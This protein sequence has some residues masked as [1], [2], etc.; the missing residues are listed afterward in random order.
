MEAQTRQFAAHFSVA[1]TSGENTAERDSN[2][3]LLY[4]ARVEAP[5]SGKEPDAGLL[6]YTLALLKIANH[7]CQQP[8]IQAAAALR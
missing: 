7:H 3:E 5:A 6:G 2:L 8:P 4:S 1:R